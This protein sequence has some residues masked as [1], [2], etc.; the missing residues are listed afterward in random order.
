MFKLNRLG[1]VLA[2]ADDQPRTVAKFNA[3]MMLAGDVVHMVYRYAE[4]RSEFDPETQSN[5]AVDETRYAQLTPHGALL[6]DSKRALLAPS[7]PWDASGCQD[8]R[9]VPF[10]GATYLFYCG[11]DKDTAPA[12]QDRARVGIAHTD[13]FVAAE[14]LGV[15][16]HYTWDK[17]AFIFPERIGGK[18]A[19]VH[20]VSPNIQIDYFGTWEEL[21]DPRSWNDYEQRVEASTVLRAAYPWECGKV[22]GSVP[23]IRTEDGWLL[24]YHAVETFPDRPFIYRAGAAL[25]DL[26]RPS[27]VIA[28][29]PYPILEPEEEYELAGDV[30]NV[31]FPVGGYVYDGNL[32]ISYGAADRCVALAM[33]PLA[34][35][36]G[37]LRRHRI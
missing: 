22:G 13:D 27:Q 8:A 32:I 34:G 25:L 15:I 28:R 37:E 21:L 33:A 1:I 19:Y 7:E 10:E 29:L 23:P 3:G 4:W 30:N 14:K 24:I 16:D 31:V 5:Y 11:W 17:D 2:P 36:L 35:L 20:R 26:R 6:F 18:I 12:G 9:V